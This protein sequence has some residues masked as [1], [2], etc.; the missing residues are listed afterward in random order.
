[1]TIYILLFNIITLSARRCWQIGLHLTYLYIKRERS[2]YDASCGQ[3]TYYIPLFS[4][5]EIAQV[6]KHFLKIFIKYFTHRCMMTFR[7]ETHT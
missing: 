5:S 6:Y 3:I 4:N 7:N 1:M 2:A